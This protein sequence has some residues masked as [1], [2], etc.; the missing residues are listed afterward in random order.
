MEERR[1]HAPGPDRYARQKAKG[2]YNTSSVP[3]TPTASAAEI[4]KYATNQT[5]WNCKCHREV[6]TQ[7]L[8]NG[9]FRASA[10]Q[11]GM[12]GTAGLRTESGPLADDL[13]LQASHYADKSLSLS[14]SV[15]QPVGGTGDGQ[16]DD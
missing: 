15:T 6:V 4:C 14:V 12:T 7:S 2:I 8:A 11:V 5:I 3:D 10:E 1:E 16:Q 9:G 13:C